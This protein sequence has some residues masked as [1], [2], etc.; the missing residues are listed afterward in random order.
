MTPAPKKPPDAAVG[1]KAHLKIKAKAAGMAL[2]A[3][4]RSHPDGR[5]LKLLKL[6]SQ[7]RLSGKTAVKSPYPLSS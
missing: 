1:L 7:G 5:L 4:R 3:V 2:R 6:Q